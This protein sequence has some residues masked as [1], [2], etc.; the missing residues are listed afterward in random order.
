MWS[1]SEW[2]SNGHLPTAEVVQ[3]LVTEAHRRF[4]PVLDG[5]VADYIPALAAATA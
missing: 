2:V 4:A 1:V 3:E 5:Q